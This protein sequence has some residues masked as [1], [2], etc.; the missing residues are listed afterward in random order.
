MDI[1]DHAQVKEEA[2]RD[3]LIRKIAA[4]PDHAG[5]ETCIDCDDVIPAA[6]RLLVPDANRCVDCLEIKERQLNGRA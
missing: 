2:E 4:K 5:S 3:N 1:A 6:R